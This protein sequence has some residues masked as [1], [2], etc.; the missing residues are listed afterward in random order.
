MSIQF[1][2][3]A[4]TDA[5]G[6]YNPDAYLNG[7]EDNFFTDA[8]L[9][10]KEPKPPFGQVTTLSEEGVLMVVA[11]GMG[12]QNAGEVAS[13]IAIDTVKDLFAPGKITPD[14]ASTHESRKAYMEKT[15]IE[16]DKRI[17]QDV[18]TLSDKP[19]KKWDSMTDTILA[20]IITALVTY[21]LSRMGIR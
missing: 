4:Y 10:G 1:Q 16:A 3:V 18:K 21:M 9:S 13:G 15:I 12:G 2:L 5:A 19:A 17:K 8:D 20:V 14:M 11:D 6:K 7:N